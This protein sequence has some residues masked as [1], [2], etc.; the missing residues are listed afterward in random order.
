M[1]KSPSIAL[2]ITTR[3]RKEE[4]RRA[5][6]SASAQDYAEFDIWVYDDASTDGTEELV[7][8]E[9]P[10]V[11]YR[12]VER[13]QG[14]IGLRNRGYQE[15][16]AEW[17]LSI[18]D[19]AWLTDR[20]TVSQIASELADCG[21]VRAFALSYL[22]S[23]PDGRN[24]DDCRLQAGDQV[25]S[26]VGTAHICHRETF[27]E[28]GGYREFLV[29]QG[30]ERDFCIRLFAAGF[31]IGMIAA[32]PIVHGVSPKRDLHRMHRW[33]TRN[34]ILFD[35]F[36][37]PIGIVVPIALK[38]AA[39]AIRYRFSIARAV[40]TARWLLSSLPA[41]WRFRKFRRP[42]T[43]AKFRDYLSLPNHGPKYLDEIDLP[44]PIEPAEPVR[45]RCETAKNGL[46]LADSALSPIRRM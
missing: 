40:T 14:Y 32:A 4:L 22:E 20:Q 35:F 11:K 15:G 46:S 38:H 21:S 25:R 34:L 42:L 8:L 31:E 36:Y 37:A 17:I 33:G 12:R 39:S 9:F 5:L 30:E 44:A 26:F 45:C 41:M 28:L 6:A 10:A 16:E 1:N 13:A 27:L 29:H 24:V 3:D 2:V 18:D 7:R 43:M 19:D 23:T